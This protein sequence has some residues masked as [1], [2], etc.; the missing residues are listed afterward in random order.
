MTDREA[1]EIVEDIAACIAVQRKH[2]LKD[3]QAL[4]RVI[5]LAMIAEPIEAERMAAEEAKAKAECIASI[6]R[7]IERLKAK[8]EMLRAD[9]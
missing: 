5:Q 9:R 6:D 3:Y 7:D 4:I 8:K 2:P 1:I